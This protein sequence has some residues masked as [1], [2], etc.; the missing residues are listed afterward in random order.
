M[1][2]K[3]HKVFISYHHEADQA[4]ADELRRFYGESRA[5]IDRSMYDDLS[6]LLTETILKKIRREHLLDTT[7]TVVL[8]G[9]HTWGRKWVDWEIHASL[10]P[11]AE[12]TINGLVGVYLPDHRKKHFRLTD[13]IAS[14]YAVKLNWDEVEDN[15]LEAVHEAYNRRNRDYL[16]DNSR[17][18]R[19]RNAS[20]KERQYTSKQEDDNCFIATA[21]FGTVLANELYVLRSWR[22]ESLKSTILGRKIVSLYYKLS[23]SIATLISNSHSLKK[24]IRFLLHPIVR[25]FEI[26]YELIARESQIWTN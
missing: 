8:V 6:H 16:I 18:L 15:F 10:R 9:E 17:D 26:K 11:Y 23:P 22:D 20:T 13:N 25:H 5:I 7:V 4:Y 19:E 21:A 3:R 14:G 12:R 1:V 2:S 24:I